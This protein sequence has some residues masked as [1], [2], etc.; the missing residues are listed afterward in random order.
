MC[1]IVPIKLNGIDSE[2]MI[3]FHIL[4]QN[5]M[6]W[7]LDIAISNIGIMIMR[8]KDKTRMLSDSF[9]MQCDVRELQW[10]C[11]TVSQSFV[12]LFPF[13]VNDHITI[14]NHYHVRTRF[15]KLEARSGLIWEVRSSQIYRDFILFYLKDL[16]F[17]TF[18]TLL[19]MF[20]IITKPKLESFILETQASGSSL[21]VCDSL[22][23]L[24][25]HIGC[26]YFRLNC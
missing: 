4:S 10:M 9:L 8:E 5:Y 3:V 26:A 14:K 20:R 24:P 2:G 25:T 23:H 22:G 7:P 15:T 21:S 19:Y 16:D 1:Y 12:F 11:Q 17:L 13:I 18:Q 6:L